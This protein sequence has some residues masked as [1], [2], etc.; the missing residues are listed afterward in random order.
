M[1]EVDELWP[2]ACRGEREVFAE[3]MGRVERPIRRSLAPFARVVDA[4]GVVQ[5]TLLRMWLFATDRGASL[6]GENA[7]LRFAIGMARNIARN[8]ARK[9]GREVVV[10]PEDLLDEAAPP[11]STPDPLLRRAI[12]ACLDRLARRPLAALMAR[13]DQGHLLPDAQLATRL[14]MSANT[15]LQ[16]IVRARKQLAQCLERTGISIEEALQ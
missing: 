16:N 12:R 13:L 8:E 15:F 6:E 4:E 2:G 7:S 11:D 3:W 14:G 5:E 9:R 10:P 1:S